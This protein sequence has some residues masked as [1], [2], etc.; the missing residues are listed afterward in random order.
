MATNKRARQRANRAV[1]QE[2]ERKTRRIRKI[3]ATARRIGIW[4]LVF[5]GLLVLANLFFGGSDSST[6]TTTTTAA[7]ALLAV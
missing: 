2:A 6:V 7:A 1:K 3:I 4:V 5:V